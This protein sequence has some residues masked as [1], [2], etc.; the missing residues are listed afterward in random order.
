VG[1]SGGVYSEVSEVRCFSKVEE[2][3]VGLYNML[4]VVPIKEIHQL[5]S[6]K[7]NYPHRMLKRV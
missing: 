5:S 2:A 4:T 6:F 3:G 1:V 7:E